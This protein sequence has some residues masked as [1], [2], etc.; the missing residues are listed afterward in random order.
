MP[1]SIRIPADR[2][3]HWLP[4]QDTTVRNLLTATVRDLVG[5]RRRPSERKGGGEMRGTAAGGG[6]E[7]VWRRRVAR[8][9]WAARPAR[10]HRVKTF[11]IPRPSDWISSPSP[12]IVAQPADQHA[13]ASRS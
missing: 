10:H 12:R 13:R 5:R 2:Q 7:W 3:V 4:A 1:V 9:V 6:E 8:P 11:W